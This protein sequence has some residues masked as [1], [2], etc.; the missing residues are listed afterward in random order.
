MNLPVMVPGLD[1]DVLLDWCGRVDRGPFS[2]IA[3]GERITFPNPEIIVTLS[4]AAMA[5]ER[6]KIFPNV[7][8]L[9]LHSAV[10]KAKQLATLDVLSRG[11][12]VLGVGAGAREEDFRAAGAPFEKKRLSQ[13]EAQVDTLRRAWSGEIVVE[14][15]AR[16]V[17]PAPF[18][19][20][21]PEIL[22]GSI[23]PRGI[24]RAARWADGIVSFS[25]APSMEEIGTGFNAAR[26]AWK[27][28]GRPAPRLLTSC[29]FALG[30]N[31]VAQI[32]SYVHRYL[33]FLGQDFARSITP[34]VECT[35]PAKLG[36]ILRRI[37]D[38]GADEISLVPTSLDAD[39]VD[40]A[41]D[42]IGAVL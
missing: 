40:R 9:P 3:A 20:E 19:K 7:I 26:E 24:R 35:S 23:Y 34:Q 11:R 15:A 41:A 16:P 33:S 13:L 10:L 42:V 39:E 29:W 6:V 21:G 27:S 32:E 28:Q 18:Q 12:L 37:Q 25:F 30:P 36:E 1:R 4:A 5:T 22:A 17:E 14:G 31:P 38:L 2:H 8:V